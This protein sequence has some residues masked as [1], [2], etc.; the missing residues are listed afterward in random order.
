MNT[1]KLNKN[2]LLLLPYKFKFVGLLMIVLTAVV[3]F[4]IKL[5]DISWWGMQKTQMKVLVV[6]L[7]ILGLFLI[8]WT[9]DE[10]EDEMLEH[11]RLVAI[12]MS[13]F[14]GI[15]SSILH[16]IFDIA[17]GGA[18]GDSYGQQ[19]IIYMLLTYHFTFGFRK[20]TMA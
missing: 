15:L 11:I 7:F 6:D 12:A 1:S 2:K 4:T 18:L 16:P 13:F 3:G 20:L 9:K 8:A 10:K 14:T 5:T 19:Q 17:F